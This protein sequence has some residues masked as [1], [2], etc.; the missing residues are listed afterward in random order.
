MIYLPSRGLTLLAIVWVLTGCQSSQVGSPWAK[1]P[2]EPG[3]ARGVRNNCYSLLYDLLK[4]ESHVGLL[5]FIKRE[6]D[7]LKKLMRDIAT[8]SAAGAKQLEE[9]A[10]QDDSISLTDIWLPAGEE[11]TRRAIA[12][13]TRKELMDR[14]GE[15]FEVTLILSQNKALGYASQLAMIGAENDLQAERRQALQH[16]GQELDVLRQ[17]TFLMLLSKPR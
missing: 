16:L 17:Q 7:D 12:E 5:R 11:D 14:S 13:L 4:Q 15:R 9:F 6:D 8:R 2:R 10:A 1:S 3:V